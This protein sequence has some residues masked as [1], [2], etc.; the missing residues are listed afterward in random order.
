MK[1]RIFI[2]TNVLVYIHLFDEESQDKRKA[3]QNLLHGRIDAELIIN[4]QV[5][6][7]FYSVLLRKN[8]EDSV[9]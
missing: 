3:L 2:D 6:N 9:I 7:E 5:I 4:V 8:I 1:D